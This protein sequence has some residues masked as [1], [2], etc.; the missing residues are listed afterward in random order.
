MRLCG[1]RTRRP[2]ASS[3]TFW[4]ASS[5]VTPWVASLFETQPPTPAE[6]EEL[7]RLLDG[8]RQKTDAKE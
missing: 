6:V 7:Q 1:G 5:A 4:N 3:A 8:L 2:A